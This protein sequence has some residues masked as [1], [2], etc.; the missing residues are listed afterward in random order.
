MKYVE[1]EQKAFIDFLASFPADRPVVMLNLLKFN[2][3]ANYPSEKDDEPCAGF[4]AFVRY[5]LAVAPLIKAAG[6]ETIWQG[7]PRATLI[8]SADEQ[9]DLAVLVKYPSSQAFVDMVGSP[10]YEAVAY[11]RTAALEDSRLLAHEEL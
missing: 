6:G 1:P 2:A 3:L 5:G 7:S 4:D 9:W 11:H 10:T 8:G